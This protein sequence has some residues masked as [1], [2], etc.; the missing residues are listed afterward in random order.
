MVCLVKFPVYLGSHG[1][2]S[3]QTE[4]RER[5]FGSSHDVTNSWNS[6][7][8]L[9]ARVQEKFI[10]EVMSVPTTRNLILN[11]S[12]PF[13]L[14]FSLQANITRMYLALLNEIKKQDKQTETGTNY[15]CLWRSIS[16]RVWTSESGWFGIHLCHY[17]TSWHEKLCFSLIGEA[18]RWIPRYTIG[19]QCME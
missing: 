9:G 5:P 10:W 1:E 16:W 18:Y 3:E 19:T 14:Y 11:L 13:S 17:I 2:K 7:A 12:F 8:S 15:L 6:A 4:K